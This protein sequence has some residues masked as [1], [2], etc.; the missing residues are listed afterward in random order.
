MSA[1]T[2]TADPGQS[3]IEALREKLLLATLPHVAFDGWT[4]AALRAGASDA[5]LGADDIARAFPGGPVSA[6][7]AFNRRADRRMVEA[8]QALDTTAMRTHEKI[9]AAIRARL[10][11]AAAHKEAVRRAFAILALP[12]N[13]P[14]ALRML[15]RTVDAA[16]HAAGDRS[17]DFNWYTKRGLLAGVYSATVLYWL[18]DKS[19]GHGDTWAFLDRRLDEVMRV[20]GAIGRAAKALG[21]FRS[22]F[23]A[24][25]GGPFGR[26]PNAGPT[27]RPR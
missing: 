17:T 15:H 25:R 26:G 19:E 9:A 20:G 10:E 24:F 13:A 22:P 1:E 2:N 27:S 16:W 3:E 6:I 7:D 4:Q 21:D 12:F 11:D 14:L 5:G 23:G 18:N 8:A